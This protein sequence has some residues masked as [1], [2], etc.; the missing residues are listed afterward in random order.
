ML[1]RFKNNSIRDIQQKTLKILS[2]KSCDKT[3]SLDG[4]VNEKVEIVTKSFPPS[5]VLS[6]K[7][8]SVISIHD[9][10]YEEVEE[11]NKP[12]LCSVDTCREEIFDGKSP[13]NFLPVQNWVINVNN[14]FM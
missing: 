8:E 4:K 5:P 14:V 11:L 3:M 10:I 7:Y 12:T 9:S 1:K 13:Y 2:T 6:T